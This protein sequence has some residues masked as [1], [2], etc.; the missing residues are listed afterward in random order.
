MKQLHVQLVVFNDENR[1]GHL[2]CPEPPISLNQWYHFQTIKDIGPIH[3][4][5]ARTPQSRKPM[6]GMQAY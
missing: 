5:P 3:A 6:S 4:A 1:L 2:E